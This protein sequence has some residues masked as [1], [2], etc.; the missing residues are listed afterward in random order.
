[1]RPNRQSVKPRRDPG[2]GPREHYMRHL[3]SFLV[4]GHEPPQDQRAFTADRADVDEGYFD[5]IGIPIVAGRSFTEADREGTQSVAIISNAIARHFWPGGD[6]IGRMIRTSDVNDDDLVVAG[7][8]A[9]AKIRTIGETPRDMIYRPAAQHETRGPTVVARTS[10]NAQQTALALMS[11][12]RSIDP[13]FWVWEVKTMERHWRW[14]GC[15]P[16]SRRS[17]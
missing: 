16:N 3:L 13:D 14:G 9:D 4:D 11:A 6:A 15:R 10:G 8:A 2:F 12:G 1:M 7:I 5:A 17:S